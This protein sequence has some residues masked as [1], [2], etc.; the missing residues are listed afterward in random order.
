MN[1]TRDLN[2]DFPWLVYWKCKKW[3]NNS[4]VLTWRIDLRTQ[5]LH[6]LISPEEIGEKITI[7]WNNRIDLLKNL[8]EKL[9]LDSWVRPRLI[10]A[11][12]H[13]IAIEEQ[14]CLPLKEYDKRDTYKITYFEMCHAWC[15]FAKWEAIVPGHVESY[16][17]EVKC[18][19]GWS[20]TIDCN[21]RELRMK[22]IRWEL[23][24]K[25]VYEPSEEYHID[26]VEIQGWF[27]IINQDDYQHVAMINN[28]K[29]FL[30]LSN[31]KIFRSIPE[32]TIVNIVPIPIKN[33]EIYWDEFENIDYNGIFKIISYHES[34]EFKEKK[35]HLIVVSV[36]GEKIQLCVD[37]NR[38]PA[39]WIYADTWSKILLEYIDK[40]W[41]TKT[42]KG[43]LNICDNWEIIIMQNKWKKITS[44]NPNR[45][46]SNNIDEY[47]KTE[48]INLVETYLKETRKSWSSV[49]LR[50]NEIDFFQYLNDI[51][52]KT[53]NEEERSLF[54]IQDCLDLILQD[55]ATLRKDRIEMLSNYFHIFWPSV[56]EVIDAYIN[57]KDEYLLR[58]WNKRN[59]MIKSDEWFCWLKSYI[60]FWDLLEAL[61]KYDQD[62]FKDWFNDKIKQLIE[63]QLEEEIQ[64][65]NN[66]RNLWSWDYISEFIISYIHENSIDISDRLDLDVLE[67]KM[68]IKLDLLDCET[69]ATP[70]LKHWFDE[71][72][73]ENIPIKFTFWRNSCENKYF[74]TLLRIWY[75]IN[76]DDFD[77]IISPIYTDIFN[78][79]TPKI[80][81]LLGLKNG[82]PEKRQIHFWSVMWAYTET[83]HYKCLRESD[84]ID[85]GQYSS[86][87]DIIWK[88]QWCIEPNMI[89]E[90]TKKIR[91]EICR[92]FP[93]KKNLDN[94]DLKK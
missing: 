1:W 30:E 37:E 88:L 91:E 27:A 59:R 39:F 14:L 6:N 35:Y 89:K 7:E 16:Q 64:S 15:E 5:T 3:V 65:F 48:Y 32:D 11:L 36:N 78:W 80:S 47:S 2:K 38:N 10:K 62:Y 19:C 93:L 40:D 31:N 50:K 45:N 87:Y 76:I 24:P 33:I 90:K 34:I 9:L 92:Q 69:W 26:R 94:E 73:R 84:L 56:N 25:G 55:F 21:P 79:I 23:S 71:E 20:G 75:N 41:Y 51:I 74:L 82:K 46:I 77:T 61:K 4:L 28:A 42:N 81:Y 18:H 83:D 8:R 68:L 43:N 17:L 54:T 67:E 70:S 60:K 12:N 44:L 86:K 63:I 53:T 66:K 29:S 13:K 57:R 58:P 49:W 85:L 72:E 52:I 22:K